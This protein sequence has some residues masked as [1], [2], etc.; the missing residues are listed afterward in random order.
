MTR[1]QAQEQELEKE[2]SAVDQML[3]AQSEAM[4]L[5]KDLRRE[6]VSCLLSMC[7]VFHWCFLDAFLSI[8]CKIDVVLSAGERPQPTTT[9]T[10]PSKVKDLQL[11]WHVTSLPDSLRLS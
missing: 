7:T 11:I 4:N 9:A 6:F 3:K 1:R 8:S 2:K 5:M 10:I